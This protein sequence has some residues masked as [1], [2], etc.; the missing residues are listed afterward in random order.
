MKM[1]NVI[2][3]KIL[4]MFGKRTKISWFRSKRRIEIYYSK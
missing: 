2:N 1:E 4:G 3:I